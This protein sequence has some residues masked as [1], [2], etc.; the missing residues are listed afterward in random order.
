MLEIR[1]ERPVFLGGKRLDPLLALA[2]HAK[3]HRLHPAGGKPFLYFFPEYGANIIT[4]DP[5]EHT[6]GLLRIHKVD[7]DITRIVYR[8]LYGRLGYFIEFNSTNVAVFLFQGVRKMPRY[9]LAF[10]IGVC[11]QQ[12]AG[13]LSRLFFEFI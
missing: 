9:R 6:A 7:I 13:R 12:H 4:D 1:V 10:A 5:V 8:F 2:D 11:R 3:G